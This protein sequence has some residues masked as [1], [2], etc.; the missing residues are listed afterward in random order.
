MTKGPSLDPHDKRLAVEVED[1]PL[2]YGD[3]EGTIPKGEYGGGT[4][5]LWDRGYWLPEGDNVCRGRAA[6]GRAQVRAGRRQAARQLCARAHEARP[7]RRQAQQLAADQAQGRV[8]EARQGRGDPQQGPLRSVG[9]HHGA[10]RGGQGQGADAVHAVAPAPGQARRRLALRQVEAAGQVEAGGGAHPRSPTAPQ[11]RQAPTRRASLR[12]PTTA[13]R[14]PASPSPTRTSRCGRA[15]DEPAVTKLDLA[16]YLEVHRPVD[17]RAHPRAA[18]LG[19]PRARRHR[20]RALLPA[21]CHER[22]R[23]DDRAGEGAGRSRALHRDRRPRRPRLPWRSSAASS[24][25]PGTARRSGPRCRGGSCST[26]IRRRMWRLR[27]SSRRR[28]SC[29]SASSGSGSSPSARRRAAR[30]CTSSR[31]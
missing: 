30:A 12:R 16:R 22:A 13:T 28:R 15:G 19:H 7:R 10:D 31:R 14:S 9:A 24:S 6:Q 26:S 29:A 27:R 5:M 4:V 21:P 2:D 8:G 17:A 25:I 3:F 23:Q 1:H 20:R 11:A 18:V